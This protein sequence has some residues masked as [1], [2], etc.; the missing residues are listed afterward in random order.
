MD[1]WGSRLKQRFDAAPPQTAAAAISATREVL[2]SPDVIADIDRYS[3]QL[4]SYLT[5]R[6]KL[7]GGEAVI[8]DRLRAAM[9]TWLTGSS[10]MQVLYQEL[11]DVYVGDMV[12]PVDKDVLR[13]L[14]ATAR[15]GIQGRLRH[16]EPLASATPEQFAAMAEQVIAN[17]KSVYE[18]AI[19]SSL[20]I[21]SDIAR[22]TKPRAG[23]VMPWL[24]ER[25]AQSARPGTTIHERAGLDLQAVYDFTSGAS[26]CELDLRAKL[27]EL[28]PEQ[29]AAF[30]T[31]MR[32]IQSVAWGE[33]CVAFAKHLGDHDGDALADDCS[34]SCVP[35]Q[36]V[37]EPLFAWA[38]DNAEVGEQFRAARAK[39]ARDPIEQLETLAIDTRGLT[40]IGATGF[41]LQ[42]PVG[43]FGPDVARALI[44]AAAI[45]KR[46]AA[47]SAAP[48]HA[49]ADLREA[50]QKTTF[51]GKIEAGLAEGVVSIAQ[52]LA[53]LMAK[54]PPGLR[55]KPIAMLE[56]ID[57]SHLVTQLAGLAPFAVL[58]PMAVT[59]MVPVDSIEVV[60]R[61][62]GARARLPDS[63]VTLLREVHGA[64]SNKIHTDKDLEAWLK[65]PNGRE[66]ARGCP[67]AGRGPVVNARGEIEWTKEAPLTMLTHSFIALVKKRLKAAGIADSTVGD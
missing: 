45:G 62:S 9:V 64:R 56:L 32:D 51:P 47:T 13:H 7:E 36:S 12:A 54:A 5:Y 35:R 19:K 30:F 37:Q 21:M 23:S 55:G 2:T 38:G 61:D 14:W 52:T 24:S 22:D 18:L 6:T 8:A 67:V 48:F 66:T 29:R 25:V 28:A 53:L 49:N 43:D 26:G 17:S 60:Q 33:P 10:I 3:V 20:P 4:H 42:F 11:R 1:S 16:L 65:S 34:F 50:L 40:Q 44:E 57:S 27:A 46:V 15:E 31:R 63:L 58:G 41:M 39:Q 59:G